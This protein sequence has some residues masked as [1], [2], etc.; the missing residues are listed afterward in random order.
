MLPQELCSEEGKEIFPGIVQ[1][2]GAFFVNL[3]NLIGEKEGIACPYDESDYVF[4]P[5]L[6]NGNETNPGFA[7][8]KIE[9]PKPERAPLCV[10]I[11]ICH[12]DNFENIRYY[13][14]ELDEMG[15]YSLCEWDCDRHLNYG[16]APE[17]EK[18]LFYK[19]Y[20]IYTEYLG[21]KKD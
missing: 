10:A 16:S 12:Q 1:S 7:I 14:L 18:E 3:F 17:S 5:A 8:L 11:F 9:L 20:T 15:D 19:I 6:I 4:K 13:T 21:S 2:R